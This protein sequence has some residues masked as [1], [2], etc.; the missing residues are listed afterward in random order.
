MS[1]SQAYFGSRAS[2]AWN[3]NFNR[4][5]KSE[6]C[7]G[8]AILGNRLRSQ[9]KLFDHPF[10]QHWRFPAVLQLDDD[11]IFRQPDT[12]LEAAKFEPIDRHRPDA[13]IH[14][15]PDRTGGRH[16]DPRRATVSDLAD[17]PQPSRLQPSMIPIARPPIVGFAFGEAFQLVKL[18]GRSSFADEA[19]GFQFAFEKRHRI[20]AVA[21]DAIFAASKR[22]L[23]VKHVELFGVEINSSQIVLQK[24]KPDFEGDITLVVFGL[25]KISKKSPEE[26][27]N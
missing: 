18:H 15:Q 17:R 6:R 9:R 3:D 21:A 25:T 19:T 4:F 12:F 16:G 20:R 11:L 22:T 24:T 8:K 27:V 10:E 1:G 5:D 7:R 26:T 14:G 13:I 23:P 2:C